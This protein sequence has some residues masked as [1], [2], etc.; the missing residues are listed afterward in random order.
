M[1]EK[2]TLEERAVAIADDLAHPFAAL[3]YSR[4]Y[5]AALQHLRAVES[6]TEERVRR[7]ERERCAKIAA[8]H[9]WEQYALAE[10]LRADP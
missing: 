6:E 8:S 4:G 7:E 2:L 5:E 10:R 3:G 1:S 9:P